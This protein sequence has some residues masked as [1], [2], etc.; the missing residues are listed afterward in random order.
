MKIAYESE[1]QQFPYCY[2][3]QMDPLNRHFTESTNPI[4]K[5]NRL[6]LFRKIIPVYCEN[7]ANRINTLCEQAVEGLNVSADGSTVLG[8]VLKK[9][10]SNTG[11]CNNKSY[12]HHHI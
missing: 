12:Y 8:N 5:I 4:T 9:V 1:I 10:L 11:S 3:S 6:I 7:H 2:V